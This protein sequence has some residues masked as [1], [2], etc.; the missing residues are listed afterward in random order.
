M[1][2]QMTDVDF[3]NLGLLQFFSLIKMWISLEFYS[4]SV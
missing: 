3:I 4:E 2:N 1:S